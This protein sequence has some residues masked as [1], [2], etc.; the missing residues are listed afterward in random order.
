MVYGEPDGLPAHLTKIIHSMYHNT[1]S[2]THNG[3]RT[4]GKLTNE[5]QGVKR[6]RTLC[7]ALFNIHM[8]AGIDQ[9]LRNTTPRD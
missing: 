2:T 7:P 6:G 4:G 1:K 5:N 9:M 8:D 3:W